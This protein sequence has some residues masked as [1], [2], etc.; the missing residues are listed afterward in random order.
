MQWLYQCHKSI[1]LLWANLNFYEPNKKETLKNWVQKVQNFNYKLRK[2]SNFFI[3][4]LHWKSCK[5][6]KKTCVVELKQDLMRL[7][8][9]W[10]QLP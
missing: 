5:D 1:S 7:G 9:L 3:N 2:T 10:K 8:I 6:V 4:S